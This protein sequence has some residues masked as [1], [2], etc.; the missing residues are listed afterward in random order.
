MP[1]TSQ[2]QK[3]IIQVLLQKEPLSSS[4]IQAQMMNDGI[5]LSLVTVKRTLSAM[6][7]TGRLDIEGS[8]PSTVYKVSAPGRLFADVDANAYG[9]IEPDKRYG[10]ERYNFD[11]LDAVPEHLFSQSE[12]HQ[13][14]EATA[15]YRQRTI[16]LAP[17]I[18]K[19]EWER[20]VV[21]LSWKSS[22]IEGNTYTL[23]D[24]E[25]L[26]L[27]GVEAT[28]HSKEEAHMIL[29]HKE[30][31]AF[32]HAHADQFKTMTRANLEQLH[33]IIVKNLH[34]S[35]GLR[36]K[37]VG[38]LGSRYRP[39]DNVHQIAEAV[40]GLCA[41]IARMRTPYDKALVALAGISYIQPFEDGNKRT[42]R[43]MANALLLSHGYAP[44]SYRSLEEKD[45][46]D[47]IL[48]FYELNSLVPLKNIFISQYDF[49]ARNYAAT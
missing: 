29:N 16:D 21:E 4:A 2:N 39:L 1:K 24:T 34:I 30:A 44:L 8:G 45:Y 14:N 19:K 46:R 9:A 31:F 47:A 48:V 13:L 25:K 15:H 37:A 3:K 22:K 40:D 12:R 28:G 10:L 36:K 27:R 38:V 32:A 6:V 49:A 23:L 5:D 11:L 35:K 18:Q 7:N 26:L 17:G 41:T 20:L 42:S 43:L 33:S